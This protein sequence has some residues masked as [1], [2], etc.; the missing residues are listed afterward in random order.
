[1]KLIAFN[2]RGSAGLG[3]LQ[4]SSVRGRLQSEPQFPGEL[5]DLIRRPGPIELHC[6]DNA[7]LYPL[8][9]LRFRPP[10]SRPGKII[11]VGLNY[12]DHTAESNYQQP[13]YPTLFVRFPTSLVAHLEPI[14]R[15]R[16]SNALDY[17]G[18]M[19]AVIGRGGRHI[20]KADALQYVSGYSIFNDAS[21]RDYQHRTPQWTVGKNFD[22]T[23]SFG[24]VFVTADELPAGGRGLKI[25]TRLNDAVVQA[26]NT[27][28]LIFDVATLISTISEAMTL[29]PG[30]I[31]VTGTPA[32][33]GHSRNPRLYMKPGDVVEVEI[34][35]IGILR[36]SI[37]DE[38]ELSAQ[39]RQAV[40]A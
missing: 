2:Y 10:L 34:E 11:C 8:E 13:D 24:P 36:N 5:D 1:M 32:G 18:E 25:Q 21:I 33:V 15:P 19:V 17:E 35:R 9:S 16:V 40:G 14:V 4:G 30:D 3:V 7:P 31:I 38:I 20:S 23:G 6:F 37:V 22:G 26:S 27:D 39:D 28:S 29:A 12:R